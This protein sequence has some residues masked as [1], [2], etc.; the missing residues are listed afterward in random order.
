MATRNVRCCQTNKANI[1]TLP[2]DILDVTFVRWH[3]FRVL[4]SNFHQNYVYDA[5]SGLVQLILLCQKCTS[6]KVTLIFIYTWVSPSKCLKQK[7]HSSRLRRDSIYRIRLVAG[8]LADWLPYPYI[9]HL[10]F[11]R[12]LFLP[13][14]K[15]QI[16]Q[17][18]RL[19]HHH[20]DCQVDRACIFA[21]IFR[22][23]TR[24]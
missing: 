13:K 23:V 7:F 16:I 8:S 15:S 14:I 2:R 21:K 24:S 4:K 1:D 20:G 11:F 3:N 17:Q 22:T 12:F 10:I 6:F 19:H 18:T 5:T 9:F